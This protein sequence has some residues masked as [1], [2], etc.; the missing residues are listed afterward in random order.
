[1]EFRAE[2]SL[3]RIA[4]PLAISFTLRSAFTMVD[5]FFASRIGDGESALAATGISFPL[6]FAFIA[7]W[8]GMSTALT[9]F[10]SQA[11]AKKDESRLRSLIKST[12]KVA[13]I[14]M[15]LFVLIGVGVYEAAP[16]LGLESDEVTGMFQIYGSVLVLG[17]AACG[18][19]SIVPDS[20]LKA[21]QDTKSTMVAGILS[22]VMNVVLNSVFLFAFGWGIFGLALATGLARFS[23][24][25]YS[26]RAVRRIERRRGIQRRDTG[27]TSLLSKETESFTMRPLMALAIPAGLSYIL[28]SAENG[29][30]NKVLAGYA[31]EVASLAAFGIFNRMTLFSYMPVIGMAVSI[32]PFVGRLIG[33]GRTREAWRGL[34]SAFKFAALYS[35]FVVIPGFYFFGDRIAYFLLKRST[36]DSSN[37][38]DLATMALT[39]LLPIG[40]LA[41]L[42]F[43]ICRPVFEAMQ[44][45]THVLFVSSLRYLLFSPGFVILGSY[46]FYKNDLEPFLGALTGLVAA[47][48]LS[49]IIFIAMLLATWRKSF[50]GAA[51]PAE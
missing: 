21:Y 33:E 4:W 28:I 9:S 32:V 7:C 13:L 38:L 3:F 37:S 49:S 40:A 2:T 47:A 45:G 43:I 23:S 12:N 27:I 11:I 50:Q 17:I 42:P 18:F 48:G 30:I 22:G 26:L 10:A 8:V 15:G 24:Y 31:N 35:L 29:I 25:I 19:W 51:A 14:L 16:H 20:L 1:M 44:K 41:G 5:M 6:E 39:I 34:M 46:L 36:E